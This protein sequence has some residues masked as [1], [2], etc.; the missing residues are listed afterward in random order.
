MYHNLQ[1]KSKMIT[2]VTTIS[3]IVQHNS[4]NNTNRIQSVE[5]GVLNEPARI[6]SASFAKTLII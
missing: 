5:G 6:P 2:S 3:C 1:T 4:D